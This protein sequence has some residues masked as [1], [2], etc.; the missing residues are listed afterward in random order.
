MLTLWDFIEPIARTLRDAVVG[1]GREKAQRAGIEVKPPARVKKPRVRPPA[2]KPPTAVAPSASSPVVTKPKRRR[3]KPQAP[4][5]LTAPAIPIDTPPHLLSSSTN[6]TADERYDRITQLMLTRYRVRVRKWRSGMTGMAWRVAYRDGSIVN[7]IEAPKPKGPMSA[8]V[9][10]HEIGH[11][12]IGFDT[13]KPRCLEEY[14]AWRWSL[15]AMQ[16]LG[17]N[18]TDAVR[19]RMHLSLWYAVSKAQR[20]GIRSIPVELEP[21]MHRPARLSKRRSRDDHAA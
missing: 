18:I 10:L 15:E 2:L 1:K 8:A 6:E 4:Q 13:Y 12:A 20:R 3:R 14:H 21:F 16:T 7:L 17:L 5:A 11:H 9:F 19:H